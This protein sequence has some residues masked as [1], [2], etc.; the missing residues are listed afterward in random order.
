MAAT[1]LHFSE[2]L[3]ALNDRVLEM[4]GDVDSML[5][6]AMR[7]LSE[8]SVGLAEEVLTRDDEVDRLDLEIESECMRLIALQQ[9]MG[10]DLRLIGT[11][12]KVITDLERIGDHAVDIAKVARKLAHEPLQR[13]LVDMPR[14]SNAVR[15]MLK[16][17][18]VA[19]VTHDLS[20][21]TRVVASD[22]NVDAMF[23]ILRDELHETMR[24]N[25]SQVVQASYLLFVA[26]YLERIADHIVNI[27][28][29]VH[30]T[31]TG[32]LMPSSDQK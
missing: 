5:G 21:V 3:K 24:R 29:R 6:L 10:R 17:V 16:D 20:L 26:H 32:Q 22:D 7:A 13:P 27:A 15:E 25:S 8:H 30:Y 19:F 1:R 12:I 23:H 14:L 2:E 11:A 28:E 18:M 4:C 31:E 9:P